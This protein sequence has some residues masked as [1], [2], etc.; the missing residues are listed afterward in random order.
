MIEPMPAVVYDLLFLYKPLTAAPEH[1]VFP[2]SKLGW[3]DPQNTQKRIKGLRNRAG[4][5]EFT[6]YFARKTFGTGMDDAGF[7]AR[8]ISDLLGKGS[9]RDTQETYMGRQLPNPAAA[10]AVDK[11]FGPAEG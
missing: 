6:S 1:P 7:S 5:E 8:Q 2:D 4:F 9:V 10:S 11:L 3:R